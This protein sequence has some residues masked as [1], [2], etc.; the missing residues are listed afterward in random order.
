MSQKYRLGKPS[1][2]QCEQNQ[3]DLM[4]WG[5]WDTSSEY[6]KSGTNMEW[7]KNWCFGEKWFYFFNWKSISQTPSF[8]HFP[9]Q[10]IPLCVTGVSNTFSVDPLFYGKWMCALESPSNKSWLLCF[11][12]Y[13]YASHLKFRVVDRAMKY[14]PF[15][16]CCKIVCASVVVQYS[17]SVVVNELVN[18][19]N[20]GFS[21]KIK[22]T[23]V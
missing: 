11:Q 3:R 13:T 5:H 21:L 20:F 9:V 12:S 14:Y 19:F 18:W 17:T 7:N 2:I 16:L 10:M 8:S 22:L 15:S 4:A 6:F 23:F 1:H